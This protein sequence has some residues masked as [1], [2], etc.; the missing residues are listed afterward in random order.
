MHADS[1]AYEDFNDPK[2]FIVL[3]YKNNKLDIL[4]E[5][6]NGYVLRYKMQA[7]NITCMQI[8][9]IRNMHYAY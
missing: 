6:Y 8:P 4:R 7:L 1:G 9:L 3:R 5:S 2:P